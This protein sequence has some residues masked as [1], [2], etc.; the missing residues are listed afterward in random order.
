[1]LI[2]LNL[3]LIN[4]HI[5]MKSKAET[6]KNVSSKSVKFWQARTGLC[7]ALIY[8]KMADGTFPKNIKLGE[9]AMA[10]LE[11]DIDNWI[12]QLI[13]NRDKAA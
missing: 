8:T 1:M 9:R 12:D 3:P 4:G 5:Y 2:C 13:A 7:I 11:S 10:W 6:Q